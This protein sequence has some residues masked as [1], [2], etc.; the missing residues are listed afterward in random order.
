MKFLV[1]KFDTYN[2]L[3]EFIA[4]IEAHT[5]RKLLSIQSN[6][7]TEFLNNQFKSWYKG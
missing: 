7:D 2:I 6:C 1:K 4:M 3:V 5:N